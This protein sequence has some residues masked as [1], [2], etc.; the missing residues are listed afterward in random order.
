[1]DRMLAQAPFSP[2]YLG[3]LPRVAALGV[4]PWHASVCDLGRTV[5]LLLVAGQGK[6]PVWD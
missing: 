6:S 5:C 3:P 1:M 4:S 2:P